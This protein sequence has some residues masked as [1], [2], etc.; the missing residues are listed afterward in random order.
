MERALEQSCATRAER[1]FAAS[2]TYA[3][4]TTPFFG[5][6]YL[7]DA[8]ANLAFRDF[9]RDGAASEKVPSSGQIASALDALDKATLDFFSTRVT[10]PDA[11][12][13]SARLK[14][15]RELL[16][17]GRKEGAMLLAIEASIVL[18][19]RGGSVT[20]T[21]GATPPAG[22]IAGSQAAPSFGN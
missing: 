15:A 6:V 2:L 14:E 7:G 11:I 10:T 17:A 4:A 20:M 5:L 16:K 18:A 3:K 22:S 12:P 21:E 9:V 1:Y 19:D 13:V 8:S